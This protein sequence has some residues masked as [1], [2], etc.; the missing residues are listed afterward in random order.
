MRHLSGTESGVSLTI[1]V[2][3]PTRRAPCLV[4]LI[5][6]VEQKGD[7]E[8]QEDTDGPDDVD[9]VVPARWLRRR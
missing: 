1:R 3:G 9:I 2:A 7:S 5:E 8:E 6:L 4:V